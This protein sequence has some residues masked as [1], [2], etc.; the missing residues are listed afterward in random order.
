VNLWLSI[1]MIVEAVSDTRNPT[2][3]K[4]PQAHSICERMHQ[5]VGDILWT[6]VTLNPPERVDSV[7][8]MSIRH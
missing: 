3:A 2:T 4:N 8:H 6:M 1:P 7:N 5:M